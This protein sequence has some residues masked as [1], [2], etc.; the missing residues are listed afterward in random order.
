MQE[1]CLTQIIVLVTMGPVQKW[2]N[3]PMDFIAVKNVVQRVK[4]VQQAVQERLQYAVQRVSHMF[5]IAIVV[6][7]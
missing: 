3:A 6:P 1:T 7:M 4:V 2:D 5:V